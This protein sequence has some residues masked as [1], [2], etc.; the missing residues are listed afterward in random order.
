MHY[1]ESK[2]NRIKKM[3]KYKIIGRGFNGWHAQSDNGGL[4]GAYG[5]NACDR[6]AEEAVDGALVYDAK[7][8][9][10]EAFYKLIM[11]GP[12]VDT[13]LADDETNP[14]TDAQRESARAMLSGLGGGFKT[15]A[16]IAQD[17]SYGGLD[18][19]SVNVYEKLLRNV[20]GVRFGRV[21]NGKVEWEK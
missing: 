5:N 17:K 18:Y 10:F 6:I 15:L 20:P 7:M 8:S 19:V 12:M 11:S 2:T 21:H 4:S 3:K 9:D 16:T 13:S 14:F 1:Q